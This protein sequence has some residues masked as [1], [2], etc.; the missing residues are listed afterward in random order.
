M[1]PSRRPRDYDVCT[2]DSTVLV[3]WYM[4]DVMADKALQRFQ[5]ASPYAMTP[6]IVRDWNKDF[7]WSIICAECGS[8]FFLAQLIRV[9]VKGAP[10]LERKL[11]TCWQ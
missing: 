5:A 1:V 7:I 3:L 9:V 2:G 10:C 4:I 6:L 8:Y 11:R